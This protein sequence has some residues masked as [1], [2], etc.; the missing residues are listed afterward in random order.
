MK[1][2]PAETELLTA[3][4]GG[5]HLKTHRT[6]DGTKVSRLHAADGAV[7]REIPAKVVQRLARRGLLVDNMK[8]PAATYLLTEEGAR[9]ASTLTRE[10]NSPLTTR[11]PEEE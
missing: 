1:L 10:G 2:S 5:Y 9:L 4:A 8:F 6:L 7:V 11:I 3:L